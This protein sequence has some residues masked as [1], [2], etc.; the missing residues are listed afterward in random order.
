MK[1]KKKV[2]T[3]KNQGRRQPHV[4][5]QGSHRKKEGTKEETSARVKKR[6]H[7]R[8]ARKIETTQNE[9]LKR[10]AKET[11]LVQPITE[12]KQRK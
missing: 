5:Q 8:N 3:Q 6:A 10:V 11:A 9:V 7:R 1:E 12:Q 4:T 2:I